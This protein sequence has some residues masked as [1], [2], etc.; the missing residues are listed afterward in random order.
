M[1]VGADI[2][3][4]QPGAPL[5]STPNSGMLLQGKPAPQAPLIGTSPMGGNDPRFHGFRNP[6]PGAKNP[7]GAGALAFGGA[8]APGVRKTGE[9]N[10][11]VSPPEAAVPHPPEYT[12]DTAKTHATSSDLRRQSNARCEWAA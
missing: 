7:L 9:I 10:A 6:F 12:A 11:P 2:A 3:K 1:R 4:I 5:T 8:R